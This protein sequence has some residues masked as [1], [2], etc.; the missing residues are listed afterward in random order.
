MSFNHLMHP[1]NPYKSKRPDFGRLSLKYD[2][3]RP[4]CTLGITGKVGSPRAIGLFSG[5]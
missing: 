5:I 1:R 2:R 3:F 4:F